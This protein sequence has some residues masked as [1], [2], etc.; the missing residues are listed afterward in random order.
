MP[1]DRSEK[2]RGRSPERRERIPPKVRC[3]RR[4]AVKPVLLL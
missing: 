3:D 1:E 4:L 2:R